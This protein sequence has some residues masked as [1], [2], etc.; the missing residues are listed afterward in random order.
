MIC[1]ASKVLQIVR[2]STCMADRILLDSPKSSFSLC[3]EQIGLY[4]CG[5]GQPSRE[6]TV[7]E[8]MSGKIKVWSNQFSKNTV[9]VGQMALSQKKMEMFR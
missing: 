1:M 8:G 5:S 2:K 3:M 4:A 7:I 9:Q 6:Q